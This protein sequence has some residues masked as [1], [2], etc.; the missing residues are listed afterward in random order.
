MKKVAFI[1]IH[2]GFNFGSVLQTIATSYLLK[3]HGMDPICV[4]YIP[5][6]TSYKRYWKDGCSNIVK[7]IRRFLFFPFYYKANNNF[8]GYLSRCCPLSEKI[9]AKDDFTAV[10]PK[11]DL[12]VT[13]S[14]QV[15][16]YKHNE[17]IDGHYFFDGINGKKIALS[18]SIGMTDLTVEYETYM[19]E[20]L[21]EYQHL[22][23]REDT[24]V[25][26]LSSMGL[27]STQLLDPTLLIDKEDWKEYASKRLVRE[28]YLFVYLPYNT[29]D[30]NLVYRTVRKISNKHKLTVVTYSR[31]FFKV[32]LADKT[33]TFA[34]PGDILSLILHADYVVT[35][36]FHGTAFSINL[37]KQFWVYMPSK[38]STRLESLLNLCKLTSRQLKEEINQTQLN[39]VIDYETSNAILASERKK[40]HEFLNTALK[41]VSK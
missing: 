37:N 8:Y 32:K 21:R 5:P 15:W 10:C 3:E 33:I 28:G 17:G 9:Y 35:N 13:G 34:N 19:K 18:S 14:D 29:E 4:N 1:T 40:A 20:K 31:D 27:D 30:E 41:D 25:R 7:F 26:L 22:S 36:S 11:A 12:Y 16:N 2:I 38:F 39:E 23:V 24:A 6:R